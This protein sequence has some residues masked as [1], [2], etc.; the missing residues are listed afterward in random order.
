VGISVLAVSG[1]SGTVV[2]VP[3][4]A[5]PAVERFSEFFENALTGL[6]M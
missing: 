2:A 5:E 3:T 1:R 4:L 6:R